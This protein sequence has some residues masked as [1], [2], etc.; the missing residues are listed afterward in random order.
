MAAHAARP[1]GRAVVAQARPPE[2]EAGVHPG[3]AAGGAPAVV[4]PDVEIAVVVEQG[5]GNAA[6]PARRIDIGLRRIQAQVI[7]GHR[8][9]DRLLGDI[10]LDPG[11]R[12]IAL[13]R[14]AVQTFGQRIASRG[15][16]LATRALLQ[17]DARPLQ[18]AP[19]VAE[20]RAFPPRLAAQLDFLDAT[21]S[22]VEQQVE[23]IA[24]WL[25]D[26]AALETRRIDRASRPAP[27]PASARRRRSAAT[28]RPTHRP[29]TQRP[30]RA[31]AAVS[32]VLPSWPPSPRPAT[33]RRRRRTRTGRRTAKETVP[34]DRR[35]AGNER[36]SLPASPFATGRPAHRKRERTGTYEE[37]LWAY[38]IPAAI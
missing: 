35:I 7:A 13:E 1:G 12:H 17:V 22:A 23:A 37:K 5:G 25:D 14:V 11:P 16:V 32:P 28:V 29:V 21:P 31:P 20:D 18:Q 8:D 15:T 30:P 26:V 19:V 9:I 33:P 3:I 10:E 27:G 36:R 38:V 24:A 2:I 34:A 4:F 6:V